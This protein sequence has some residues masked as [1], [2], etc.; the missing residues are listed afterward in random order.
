MK[1]SKSLLIVFIL[2][3]GCAMSI[4]TKT[5]AFYMPDYKSNGTI[6]VVAT[7]PENNNSLEFAN[8]KVRFENKLSLNGYKVVNQASDAKFLA[9]IGYGISNGEKST[10]VM[11]IFGQ[12]GGGTTYSSGTVYGAGGSASYSGSSY[13]APTFGAVGAIPISS[14]EYTR[15]LALEIVEPNNIKNGQPVKI[16][17]SKVISTGSC[18][19]FAGVF[20]ELLE[21]MFK[22]FPGTNGET[23]SL[24]LPFDNKC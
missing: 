7:L 5:T 2:L 24:T 9:Y 18:S 16:Y 6:N 20:N 1:Y 23:R 14:T 12:T 19:V 8:Y 4:D 21:S 10:S 17:E 22:D 15:I 11:P 13:K 3:S